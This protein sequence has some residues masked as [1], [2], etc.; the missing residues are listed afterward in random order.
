MPMVL[1]VPQDLEERINLWSEKA[2]E[3]ADV[4]MLLAIEKYIED[5]E[6]YEDAVRISAAVACGE[7]EV[8]TSEEVRR[9]LGLDG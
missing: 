9:Y 3:P 8:Y 4:L 2:K 6:D 7:E 1:E 5:L